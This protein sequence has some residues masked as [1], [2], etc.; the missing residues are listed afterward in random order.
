M[1]ETNQDFDIYQNA[2]EVINIAVTDAAGTP[3]DLTT[4]DSICWVLSRGSTEIVRYTLA[5]PELVIVSID[6][7]N[8]AM[9]ITLPPATTGA[10]NLGKLYRHQAWVTLAG[11]PRPVQVGSVTVL[12]GDGCS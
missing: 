9:R 8:D 3:I 10:L 7:T 6:A 4:M 2:T 5:D 12:M 1:P 11:A